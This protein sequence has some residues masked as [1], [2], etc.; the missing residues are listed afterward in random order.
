VDAIAEKA[1]V[2]VDLA[3][4]PG[5][6]YVAPILKRLPARSLLIATDACPPVVKH[7]HVLFRS[8]YGERFVMLDVDLAQRL[9][10]KSQSIDRFSGA[11]ITNIVGVADTLREVAR[12]MTPKGRAV[13]GERFFAEGSV[14]EH[15]LSERG[16]AFATMASSG[17]FCGGIGLSLED[18]TIAYSGKGKSDPGNGLPLSSEDEWSQ[19]HLHLR[20]RGGATYPPTGG[21]AGTKARAA[22]LHR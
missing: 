22:D 18:Q 3:T 8:Q 5:G 11:G 14:T 10:F 21:P 13:L 4:G 19:V 17:S 15:R 16:H 1:L 7:Q 2:V 9:P 20:L 12:C 6:G